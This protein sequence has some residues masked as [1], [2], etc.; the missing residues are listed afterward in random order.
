MVVVDGGVV[1][2]KV[3]HKAKVEVKVQSRQAGMDKGPM[4]VALPDNILSLLLPLPLPLPPHRRLRRRQR[5]RP[6]PMRPV[7]V[8]SIR[9]LCL[10]PIRNLPRPLLLFLPRPRRRRLS[11]LRPKQHPRPNPPLLP[12][13]GEAERAI[14]PVWDRTL[15]KAPT[16][17]PYVPP[18]TSPP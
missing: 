13:A 2:H 9:L 1:D 17:T 10:L 14:M 12:A 5:H 11:L 8:P 18:I 15:V 4:R 16:M 6:V 3:V 7:E